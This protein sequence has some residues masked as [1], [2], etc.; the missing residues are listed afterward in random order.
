MS[1]PDTPKSTRSQRHQRQLTFGDALQG[2][3]VVGPPTVSAPNAACSSP[4]KVSPSLDLAEFIHQLVLESQLPHKTVNILV[5]LRILSHKKCYLTSQKVLS[6]LTESVCK[7]VLQ[8][9]IPAQIRQLVLHI[10]DHTFNFTNYKTY[11][12]TSALR[13]V[14]AGSRPLHLSG[15]SAP[16]LALQRHGL[17]KYRSISL[18]RKRNPLGPYRR[19]MPRV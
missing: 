12:F 15:F 18:T 14:A 1:L 17:A 5:T 9:L 3:G 10:S 8:K 6:Y 19:P 11:R 16:I 13:G 2:A 7:I 4:L